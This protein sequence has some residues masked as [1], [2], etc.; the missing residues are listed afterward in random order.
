MFLFSLRVVADGD[1]RFKN[2]TYGR[3]GCRNGRSSENSNL[4][5]RIL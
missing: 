3:F 1:V 2:L 5:V 4:K